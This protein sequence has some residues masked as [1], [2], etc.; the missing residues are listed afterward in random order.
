MV[1]SQGRIYRVSRL[2]LS[3]GE[4]LIIDDS[5]QRWFNLRREGVQET[6]SIISHE[7]RN[8]LASIL[9]VL[10]LLPSLE[11]GKKK[12]FMDKI[13]ERAEKINEILLR[14]SSL[15]SNPS[16]Q[17]A[18]EKLKELLSIEGAKFDIKMTDGE[19]VLRRTPPLTEKEINTILQP[20]LR[21]LPTGK[22]FAALELAYTI[23]NIDGILTATPREVRLRWKKS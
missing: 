22:G 8:P 13:K 3:Y 15:G 23:A 21:E 5:T 18:L 4:I 16:P 19:I 12:E 1:K 14:W 17:R 9:G 6:I 7:L 20:N 10:Q 11:E 2:P